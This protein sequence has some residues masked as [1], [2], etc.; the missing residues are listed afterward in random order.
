MSTGRSSPHPTPDIVRPRPSEA[1]ASGRRAW[2][3]R[4]KVLGFQAMRKALALAFGISAVA[5]AACVPN[6]HDDPEWQKPPK[7]FDPKGADLSFN[8][9]RLEAYNTMSE[10]ERAAEIERM[11]G[12]A[13]SFKGQA[14]FKRATELGDKMDDAQYGKHEV[15]AVVPEPVL[16]EI[17]LEYLLYSDQDLGSKLPPGAHIEFVGTLADISYV[18]DAKPR[19]MELKVKADSITVLKD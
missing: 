6:R 17:T 5:L 10:D 7:S 16:F 11:R 13:G 12:A 18:S 19:K 2:H 1:A 9:K 8:A 15:W 3:V 4:A 14:V